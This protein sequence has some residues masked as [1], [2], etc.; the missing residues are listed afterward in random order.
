[1]VSRREELYSIVAMHDFGRAWKR[2]TARVILYRSLVS[3]DELKEITHHLWKSSGQDVDELITVFFLPGMDTS[4]VAYGFGSCMKD[5]I[6]RISY[7]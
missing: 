4:S 5:G 6:P 7:R 3:E 1:M 2:R